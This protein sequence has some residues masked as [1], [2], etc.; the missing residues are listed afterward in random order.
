MFLARTTLQVHCDWVVIL[1]YE[2][3]DH[4]PNEIKII[5]F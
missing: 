2:A 3:M 5:Y 1:T 4:L